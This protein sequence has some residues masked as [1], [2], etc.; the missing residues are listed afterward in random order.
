VLIKIVFLRLNYFL[1]FHDLTAM[2]RREMIRKRAD[3]NHVAIF[4]STRQS[5]IIPKPPQPDGAR[6]IRKAD[7]GKNQL[8]KY[9]IHVRNTSLRKKRRVRE[10][11]KTGKSP[12]NKGSAMLSFLYGSKAKIRPIIT[13]TKLERERIASIFLYCFIHLLYYLLIFSP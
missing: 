11:N 1:N 7:K 9:T 13:P 3:R 4:L 10:I 8:I 6:K 12:Q 5:L 2:M